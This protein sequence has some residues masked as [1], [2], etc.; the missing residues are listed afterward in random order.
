VTAW[1]FGTG[2]SQWLATFNITGA[3]PTILYS[4]LYIAF[5]SAVTLGV[6]SCNVLPHT[7]SCSGAAQPDRLGLDLP[8]LPPPTARALTFIGFRGISNEL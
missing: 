7:T 1:C 3:F 6:G 4:L 2:R 8:L 5:L